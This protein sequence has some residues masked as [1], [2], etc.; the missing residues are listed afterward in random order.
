MIIINNPTVSGEEVLVA[1]MALWLTMMNAA[2]QSHFIPDV[3]KCKSSAIKIFKVLDDFDEEEIQEKEN[4]TFSLLTE[5]KPE[6]LPELSCI[7]FNN[8]SFQYESVK[9]SPYKTL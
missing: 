9:N 6:P 8:V 5:E 7:K 1:I 2:N 3:G 4:P